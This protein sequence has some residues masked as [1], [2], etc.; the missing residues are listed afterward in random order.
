MQTTWTEPRIL[1]ADSKSL[2]RASS[3]LLQGVPFGIPMDTVRDKIQRVSGIL[4]V[5]E[6]HVWQLSNTKHIA[7]VHVRLL[8]SVDY[9]GLITKVKNIL[10]T[11]GIHSTTIQPEFEELA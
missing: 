10:H 8:P 5:H 1:D 6:L 4:S 2:C 7:S 11:Y 9:M 3:V